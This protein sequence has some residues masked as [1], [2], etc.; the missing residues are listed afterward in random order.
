MLSHRAEKENRHCQRSKGMAQ[1]GIENV[2]QTLSYLGNVAQARSRKNKGY[3][4]RG[5]PNT[6]SKEEV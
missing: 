2:K 4:E 5:N 1:Q 3:K 6:C